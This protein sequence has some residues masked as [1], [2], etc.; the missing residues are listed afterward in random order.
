MNEAVST[1]DP[2]KSELDP[3]GEPDDCRSR[4]PN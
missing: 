4:A 2:V 1:G 3:R